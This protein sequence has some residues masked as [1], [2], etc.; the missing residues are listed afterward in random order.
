MA[1]ILTINTWKNTKLLLMAYANEHFTPTL[2]MRLFYKNR[3]VITVNDILNYVNH[4]YS[5][6]NLSFLKNSLYKQDLRTPNFLI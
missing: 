3:S 2:G 4:Y 1:N 6:P 5:E